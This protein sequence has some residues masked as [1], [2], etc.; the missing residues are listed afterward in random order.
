LPSRVT[1]DYSAGKQLDAVRLGS[2]IDHMPDSQ[3]ST[4]T[5][6]ILSKKE[7]SLAL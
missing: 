4:T 5:V 3:V 6:Y 7:P 1:L 2:E